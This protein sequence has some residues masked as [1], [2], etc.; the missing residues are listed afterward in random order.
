[1][2]GEPTFVDAAFNGDVA[3]IPVVG[4]LLEEH[5]ISAENP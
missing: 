2:G 3:P 4:G 5:P 1:M